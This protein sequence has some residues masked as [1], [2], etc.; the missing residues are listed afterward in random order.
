LLLSW[1]DQGPFLKAGIPAI[2]LGST[3][4][5]GAL[6]ESVYH[7]AQDTIENLRVESFAQYGRTAECIV[8]SL[9]DLQSIP[10]ESAGVLRAI[11]NIF[12]SGYLV[13]FMQ[14]LAFLPFVIIVAYHIANHRRYITLERIRREGTSFLGTILPLLIIFPAI[15]MMSFLR[16]LPG[17]S[18]YPATPKDPVLQHPAWGVVLGILITAL[19][20]AVGCWFLARFLNRKLSRADF[21]VS[22]SLL[23]VLLLIVIMMAFIYNSYWA[24]SFLL[25]PSLFW[26]M[27]GFSKGA[28][29]RAAN[30]IIILAAGSLYVMVSCSFASRLGLGWKLFWYEMLALSSGMF[31]WQAFLLASATVALGLRFLMIQSHGAVD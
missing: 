19:A 18:L 31:N 23:L 25:L 7:S 16:R 17:Y 21:Y 27:V 20:F 1:T 29:A 13:V 15:R 14:V 24:V 10:H 11:D 8:R 30:R 26:G 6:E 9:D 4:R 12:I 28:G 3:A 22:K 2:N 5:E